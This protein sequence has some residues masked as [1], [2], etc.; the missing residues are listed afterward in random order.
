MSKSTI[1]N[2]SWTDFSSKVIP[3]EVPAE[4]FVEMKKAFFAGAY[5]MFSIQS[6]LANE[7]KDLNQAANE[8]EKVRQECLEFIQKVIKESK[9]S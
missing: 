6:T 1:I 2:D 8:L 9:S 3:P 4:Q 7:I 5:A